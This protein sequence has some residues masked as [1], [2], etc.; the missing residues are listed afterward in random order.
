MATKAEFISDVRNA[1]AGGIINES[2][3]KRFPDQIIENQLVKAINAT[4]LLT[5]YEGRNEGISDFPA[6]FIGTYYMTILNDTAQDR[7][8]AEIPTQIYAMPRNRGIRGIFPK[9]GDTVFIQ[10]TRQ[11]LALNKYYSGSFGTATSF[12]PEGSR[13]YFSNLDSTVEEVLGLFV[14]PIGSVGDDDEMPVPAGYEE[15]ITN[16]VVQYFMQMRAQP[17]NMSN[18]NMENPLPLTQQ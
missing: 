4:I 17:T 12:F 13:I 9:K 14:I 1:I 10:V 7:K 15:E 2:T 6:E 3:I 8:Y 18:T 5:Y 16:R 11:E